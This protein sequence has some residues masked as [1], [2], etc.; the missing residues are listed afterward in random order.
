MLNIIS[1]FMSPAFMVKPEIVCG[2]LPNTKEAYRDL[3]NIAIPSI[4]EMVFVSLIGSVNIIML[5][6]LDYAAIAAVGIAA[7]PQM[8]MLSMFFAMNVGVTAIV[9]RKKGQNLRDEANITIR[10]ALVLIVGL[11][12]VVMALTLTFSYKLMILAGAQAD[13][14]G[15][16]NEY[17]RIITYFLPVST[18]TMC[19]NAAQRGVGNTRIPMISNLAANIVNVIFNYLLIYGNWGFPRLGVSGVA[20]ASGI[21]LC[22]GMYISFLGLFGRKSNGAFL[23]IS[24]K[25][26][27][28]PDW[29][30]VK[31]IVKLGGNS[32][33]EQVA[34]R[35]GFFIYAV[36]IANLGTAVFAA[37]Q[38][39]AQFLNF[40][41]NFGNG[42]A[43]A[44]TSLVG[45]TL[46]QKRP[47]LAVV[48]GKCTQRLSLLV[49]FIF[50]GTVFLF[51]YPLVSV[52]LDRS[53]PM[54]A[55]PFSIA[56]DLMLMVALFQLP[57]TS[58]VVVSGCLRGAGDNLFVAVV[59][60]ICVA[61]IR[62]V[63]CLAAVNVFGLGILGAWGA[64]LIDMS[65]RFALA[66]R[67]FSGSKWQNIKV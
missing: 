10:N 65:L 15:I 53:D 16:A 41:F 43:V 2:P 31:S 38:V 20:W 9:A 24:L 18:L 22:V 58:A 66:Y 64:S 6:R 13:T 50:A 39:G 44:G 23:H 11:T 55:L 14:L 57:Q 47:D 46:G 7:Q 29:E 34:Q 48:Y 61:V 25:D 35:I 51:R 21:G 12:A 8:I 40:S 52:F 5:G 1:R 42:L 62:P 17:F 28:R 63:F 26:D 59:M 32:A 27:W 33:I 67:R 30:T 36:V 37:H 56:V 3:L 4:I 19:V 60:I 54:N 49:S 45:Q